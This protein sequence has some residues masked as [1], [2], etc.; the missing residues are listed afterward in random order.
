VIPSEELVQLRIALEL[1]S[2]EDEPSALS[3][4]EG[5]QTILNAIAENLEFKN[6]P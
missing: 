4:T 1:L 5:V 6:K 2:V 3:L